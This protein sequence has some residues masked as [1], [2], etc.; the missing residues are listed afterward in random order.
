MALR[1]HAAD[2]IRERVA[3]SDDTV[4]HYLAR[5]GL[6]P[7]PSRIAALDAGQAVLIPAWEIPGLQTNEPP[8]HFT[9]H[10]DGTLTVA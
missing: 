1:R 7:R 10:P 6:A 9:L 5:L 2:A 4:N 8:H 3:R